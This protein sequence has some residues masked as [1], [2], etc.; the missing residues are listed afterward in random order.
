MYQQ[1]NKKK[2]HLYFH[3]VIGG[4]VLGLFCLGIFVPFAN[5]KGAIVGTLTSLSFL[6]WIFIGFNAYG[7][8]YTKK[9]FYTYGCENP[10]S[11]K[12][13]YLENYFRR[14]YY[15][16]KQAETTTVEAIINNIEP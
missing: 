8:K 16:N 1:K 2:I 11:N 10:R 9:P 12:I 14:S 4:P 7:I 15:H 5:P 3:R 13:L 6:L